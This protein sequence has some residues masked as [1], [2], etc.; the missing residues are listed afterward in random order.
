VRRLLVFVCAVVFVDTMFYAAIAPLLPGLSERLDL[1]KTAAGVLTAAYP[2]GTLAGALP[3]GWLAARAGP[4][5]TVLLGL[6]LLVAASVAFALGDGIVLLDVARFA[7]GVGGAASWAG[8]LGWLIEAAPRS[9]R[10]E[11]I[12]T[13]IAAAVAGALF[14]PVLGAA[15]ESLGRAPVFAGVA[16]VGLALMGVAA[17]LQGAPSSGDARVRRLAAALRDRRVAAGMWLTTLP[18]LLFGTMAV[19][20]PLRLDELGA[21]ATAIGAAFLLGAALEAVLAPFVGRL[22]DRRGRALPLA[23]GVAGGGLAMIALPWPGSALALGAVIVVAAPL[24]GSLYTP[25]MALISDGAEALGIAQGFAFALV[26]AAWAIGQAVGSA[27]SARL[28][29]AR[30]D[31]LPYLLLAGLCAVTLAVLLPRLARRARAPAPA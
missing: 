26:N 19:L 10:G 5:P 24:I 6:G 2:A 16:V 4:R 25:A 22:S 8:A 12:G 9:R 21:T 31:T 11:L 27:G 17:R 29:D 30:G 15:S 14:G 23:L 28:A 18:G 7:Q 3:G 1:S 13:A 20:G